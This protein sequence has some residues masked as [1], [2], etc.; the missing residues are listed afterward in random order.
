MEK[1]GDAGLA[2]RIEKTLVTASLTRRPCP[3]A[4]PELPELG[5][6]ATGDAIAAALKDPFA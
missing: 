5:Y 1:P 2:A 3:R 6:R 4:P